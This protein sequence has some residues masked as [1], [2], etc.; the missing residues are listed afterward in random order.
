ML[1]ESQAPI[2]AKGLS[3]M[4][5]FQATLRLAAPKLR[6]MSGSRSQMRVYIAGEYRSIRFDPR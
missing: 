5:G 3:P 6:Q 2:Q 1:E 4:L